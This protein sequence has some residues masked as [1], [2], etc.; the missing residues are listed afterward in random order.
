[1]MEM[2][3]NCSTTEIVFSEM[4]YFPQTCFKISAFSAFR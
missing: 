2:T 1:M 4:D 3:V